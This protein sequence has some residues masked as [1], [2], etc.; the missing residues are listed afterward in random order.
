MSTATRVAPRV[1]AV[2]SVLA[3][4]VHYAVVPEH[5]AEWFWYGAFFTL[6]GAFQIVWAALAWTGQRRWLTVGAVGTIALIGL[7]LFTRT[8]GV[9]FGPHAGEAEEIG[10]LDGVCVAVEA[11][12]A[13]CALAA[14]RARAGLAAARPG[15]APL[16]QS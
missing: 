5:R 11:V 9:P 8:A 3:G 15:P 2:T 13:L 4:L 14:L 10:V 1:A 12:S 7:W 16:A 6:A